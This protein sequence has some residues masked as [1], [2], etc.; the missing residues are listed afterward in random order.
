VRSPPSSPVLGT[1]R[2]SIRRSFTSDSA[3]GLC[4]TPFGTTNISPG[5]RVT[6]P[7]RKSIRSEPSTTM[8]VSSVSLW[9]CQMKS[10]FSLTTLNW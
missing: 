7:S 2:G 5:R 8:K 4:S 6:A 10:P 1:P 9:W 3:Y